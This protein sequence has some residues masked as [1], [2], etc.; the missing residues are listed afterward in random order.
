MASGYSQ[1]QINVLPP[2]L[3]KIRELEQEN[4]RLQKENDELRRLLTDN[5]HTTRFTS[6]SVRR[7][8]PLPT[9]PDFRGIDRD[10]KRRKE[11]LYLVRFFFLSNSCFRSADWVYR[12]LVILHLMET[13]CRLGPRL[14]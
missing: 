7:Q 9:Y 10:Y 12:A 2:P 1:E 13:I 14:H 5:S 6:D 3:L 11:G 8:Q 4:V